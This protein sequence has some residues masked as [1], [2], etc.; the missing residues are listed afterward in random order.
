MTR[1]RWS[2]LLL[3]PTLLGCGESF[4]ASSTGG[5]GASGSTTSATAS[6]ATTSAS[7]GATSGS[8]A[9][10]GGSCEA[11]PG[12]CAECAHAACPDDYC[13]CAAEPQCGSLLACYADPSGG[14][15]EWAQYCNTQYSGG[16]AAT[17]L[18]LHCNASACASDCS[19]SEPGLDPCE[20]CLFRQCAPDMNACLSIVEC[21]LYL[22]CMKDCGPD[23]MCAMGCA[24]LY[25]DGVDLAA[26]VVAC[27]AGSCASAC[28]H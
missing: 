11:A 23:A 27:A 2:W 20:E 10:S 26:D 17:A 4:E 7:D 3:C 14:T 22:Q 24:D 1:P 18:L 12:L 6:T 9:A 5:G 16:I 8:T 13:A 21:A 28:P 19:V 15:P 25:E